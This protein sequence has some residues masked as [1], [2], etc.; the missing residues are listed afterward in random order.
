MQRISAN[1]NTICDFCNDLLLYDS[2]IYYIFTN[3][4]NKQIYEIWC[5]ECF[6]TCKFVMNNDKWNYRTI[7]YTKTK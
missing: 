4:I 2:N 5:K 6:H 3:K 7:Q 1:K